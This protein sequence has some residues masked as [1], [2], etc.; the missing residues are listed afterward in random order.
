MN[1]SVRN[2]EIMLFAATKMGFECILNVIN[3]KKDRLKDDFTYRQ[4]I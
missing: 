1:A 3:Q 2:N 4:D